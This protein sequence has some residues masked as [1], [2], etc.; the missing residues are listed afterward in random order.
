MIFFIVICI[1]IVF[2][3]AAIV[4]IIRSKKRSVPA[5]NTAIEL[6]ALDEICRSTET[7][8]N[9]DF[10]FLSDSE[11]KNICDTLGEE[12]ILTLSI[13][14]RHHP[15]KIVYS[16]IKGHETVRDIIPYRINGYIAQNDDGTKDYDFFIEAFCLL[17]NEERSFHTNGITA[18]WNHGHE[19]NLGDYLADLCR[20]TKEYKET[21]KKH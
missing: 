19:I 11:Y 12:K 14:H 2:L 6:S 16:D 5:S 3:C 17:R 13:L 10:F 4:V 20:N 7:D 21:V 1:A 15:I 18:A 9:I 8:K